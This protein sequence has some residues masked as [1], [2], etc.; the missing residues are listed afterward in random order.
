MSAQPKT[1]NIV[2]T[3]EFR[4]VFPNLFV[5]RAFKRNGKEAGEVKYGL[6]MLFDPKTI[7][8]LKSAV[9]H[10]IA[11]KWPGRDPK[12]LK[13]PFTGGDA[14]AA[15]SAANKKDGD[16][17]K[18]TV[19]VKA[20]SKFKPGVVDAQSEPILDPGRIYSGC[21]GHAELNF[22][23]YDAVGA[24]GQDG[25]TAYVNFVLKTRDGDRIA[26]KDAKTVFAG[27]TGA[28]V[29]DTAGLDDDIPF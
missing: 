24:G 25:V 16:F 4:M 12:T 5:P 19:V 15:K 27:I 14:Q 17:F 26:G 6:T 8:P 13:L 3:P 23:A 10:V 22:V 2:V 1:P 9:K 21:Y 7:E 28:T 29:D 20:S 18:G 11:E